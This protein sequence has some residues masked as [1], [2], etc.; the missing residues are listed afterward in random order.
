[1][2]KTPCYRYRGPG[3]TPCQGT[4]FHMLQLTIHIPHLK[5][6]CAATKIRGSQINKNKIFLKK[7]LKRSY[8]SREEESVG[9]T[10]RHQ[11][12][13]VSSVF[14]SLNSWPKL[15]CSKW[16]ILAEY[17]HL[18]LRRVL[19]IEVCCKQSTKKAN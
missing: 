6:P 19:K 18:S 15:M 11:R 13:F 10:N 5:I 14:L 3:S 17:A 8:I 4:R 2:P 7:I 1:M 9:K 16:T 12:T